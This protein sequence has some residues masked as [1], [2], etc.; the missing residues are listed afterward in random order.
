MIDLYGMM[1]NR[2]ALYWGKWAKT[3]FLFVLTAFNGLYG[4]VST[5]K[6]IYGRF[7]RAILAKL[8]NRRKKTFS[9][10]F[11]LKDLS[12]V[13]AVYYSYRGVMGGFS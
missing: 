7:L 13:K 9:L 11:L 3:P 5:D 10:F 1:F 2:E 4:E 6:R 8:K 12:R